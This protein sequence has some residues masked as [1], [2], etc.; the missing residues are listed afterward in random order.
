VINQTISFND[1]KGFKL[2]IHSYNKTN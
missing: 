2:K 1:F